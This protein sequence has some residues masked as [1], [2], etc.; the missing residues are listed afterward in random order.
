MPG[1]TLV[2]GWAHTVAGIEA[3]EIGN[4]A[5]QTTIVQLCSP[6]EVTREYRDLI[7]LIAEHE[8]AA[9]L[10]ERHLGPY[11]ANPS[12]LVHLRQPLRVKIEKIVT[13]LKTISDSRGKLTAE[14]DSLLRESNFQ[15]DTRINVKKMIHP[16]VQIIARECKIHIHESISGPTSFV[17]D[18]DKN[19]FSQVKYEEI[20]T[21]VKTKRK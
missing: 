2:G 20:R 3:K 17:F 18:P 21:E 13:K 19:E 11:A 1:A 6:V 12:R 15:K 4:E 16:G 9:V 10:L 8:Q 7:K 5:G 14:R